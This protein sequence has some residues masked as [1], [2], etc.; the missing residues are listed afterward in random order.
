MSVTFT[1][2]LVSTD[3]QALEG[4]M[5]QG[6]KVDGETPAGSFMITDHGNTEIGHCP[7]QVRTYGFRI[8]F[9]WGRS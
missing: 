9:A 4:F 3:E 5:L 7:K 1:V 8:F 2:K 6:R